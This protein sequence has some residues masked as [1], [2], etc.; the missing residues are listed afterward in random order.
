MITLRINPFESEKIFQYLKDAPN[1]VQK[2]AY[3]SVKRT[4][5]RVKTKLSACTR[6][7]YTA[8]AGAIKSALAISSPTYTNLTAAVEATGRTL[9]MSAFKLSRNK[10]GPIKVQVKKSGGAKA[11]PGLFY[12]PTT[13]G[14]YRGALHRRQPSRYPLRVPYGPSVPQMVE[15]PEV[16][17]AVEQ[18]A[19]QYLANRFSHEVEYRFK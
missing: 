4:V 18:D 2:A 3:F 1:K 15:K 19:E 10:K 6:E 17:A 7:T 9:P 12:S 5:T 8:K 13:T 11:V 16:F 14:K